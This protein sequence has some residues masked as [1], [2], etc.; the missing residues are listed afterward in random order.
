MRSVRDNQITIAQSCNA[1]GKTH[2]AARIAVWWYK[3]FPDSQVYTAAAPPEDNLKRLLWG[4]IGSIATKHPDLFK[5]DVSK[6]LDI[7]RSPQSFLAGVTIPSAGTEQQRE[8]K[9]SGK[10][11]PHLLFILDECDAIPDEVYK[12]IE[13]CMSGGN[14]RLLGMFNPRS[15]AGAAYRMIRDKRANVVKLSAFRHPNVIEGADRIVGAVTRETT[16]R[17]IN[18]WTRRL[19]DADTPGDDCFRLPEFL[20]GAQAVNFNGIPY[21]PMQSGFYRILEAAFS[22][23]VLGEYPP[24]GNNQ[25]IAKTWISLA[26]QRWDA[27]V[28]DHGEI[29]PAFKAIAGED[30]AEMGN[31]DNALVFRYGDYVDR[32]QTWRG[33]DVLQSAD[34]VAAQC[35]TRRIQYVSICAI[36]VGA[37]VSPE[38]N[39]KGVPGVPCKVSEKATKETE[40]GVFDRLRDQLWWLCREWLRT[41]EAMLPPDEELIEELSV[42]TYEVKNGR[43]MVMKKDVMKELLKRSPNKADALCLT[44]FDHKQAFDPI[45]L[46]AGLM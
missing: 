45:D 36:G 17:R 15:E 29:P 46:S 43:I 42:P 26:R 16:V 38:L 21:P 6:V 39:R 34:Y 28:R 33:M 14:A 2:C 8:A 30:V 18:E 7:S 41:S 9:F 3:C 35:H 5:D 13:G 31:D 44:F 37:G 23:M 20:I 1:A 27:Y 40:I 32:L 10:H 19:N 22:Y 4:E 25:L 12:G 24:Q 11:A